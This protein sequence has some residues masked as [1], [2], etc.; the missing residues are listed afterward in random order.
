LITSRMDIEFNNAADLDTKGTGWFIGF[1]DWTKANVPGISNLRYMS[2][3]QRSHTLCVK[4]MLHPAHDPRGGAKPISTGRSISIL[5]SESG[6][7]RVE[8]S[9]NPEFPPSDIV[10]HTLKRHGDFVA[11]GENLYHRWS[12]N[13]SS[14]ILTLRW[15]PE[16]DAKRI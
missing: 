6:H 15:V 4:W 1:S 3:E 2:Q 7:F 11:W 13:E 10:C 9:K 16:V 8:F 14:I 12:A 5:V